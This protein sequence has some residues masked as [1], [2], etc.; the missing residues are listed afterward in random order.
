MP[1]TSLLV[2]LLASGGAVAAGASALPRPRIAFGILFLL[3]S[4]T[5]ATLETPIGTM[6]P[7][8]PAIAVVAVVLLLAGRFRTLLDIPRWTLLVAVAFGIYLGVIALSSAFIAPGTAQSLRMVAWL[9]TSMTGGVVA[10]VLMR[11]RPDTSMEP[12]AFAG[13]FNGGV[14]IFLAVAF[15][16]AGPGFVAGI[17]DPTTILPRVTALGWEANLYASFLAMTTFFALE[18]TR[19]P[20]RTAGFVMLALILLGFPLGVTRGA[21]IGLAVGAVAYAFVRISAERRA[22]DLPRLGVAAAGLLAVGV[23]ASNV[24][25]PN[26]IERL[27]SAIVLPPGATT[28]PVGPGST[29]PGASGSS[30]SPGSA[31]A[32][33]GTTSPPATP[34]VLTLEPYPDTIAFRL[35]RVPIAL[36]DLW[37]SP[38]IGFGA[39]SFGQNHPD[40]YAGPGPD[41]IAIL[42]IVAPYEAGIIGAAAL[43]IGFLLLLIGLWRTARR[44]ADLGDRRNVGI[45]AAF[46]GSLVCI[47]VC[48]Q[49]TNAVHLA[50]NWIVI[51]AAVALTSRGPSLDPT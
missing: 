39:E 33:P 21:Y 17:Q 31:P 42:V 20:R 9:A 32:V 34:P 50:V 26:P 40:R 5:R 1:D 46:I 7:E 15:L 28:S 6:R 51:G 4:F 25:L 3:A 11:P 2:A 27:G 37:R 44:S 13:A 19:G 43:A 23:I 8:M 36:N 24:L 22:G 48:Y 14:G 49:V 38:L 10:F 45:A 30:G 16:V 41:H 35:E 12:L 47:L 18:A 29:A